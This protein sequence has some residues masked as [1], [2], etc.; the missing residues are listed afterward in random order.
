MAS[1]W[2]VLITWGQESKQVQ[3]PAHPGPFHH[4]IE[5]HHSSQP[6]L[7][8]TQVSS[9]QIS[10]SGLCFW[11]K[12]EVS[13]QW[14]SRSSPTY[15]PVFSSKNLSNFSLAPSSPNQL[16]VTKA[17]HTFSLLSPNLTWTQPNGLSFVYNIFFYSGDQ[18]LITWP[19]FKKELNINWF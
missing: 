5:A 6:S 9:L 3:Y 2:P 8:E 7:P 13:Q 16:T 11:G 1:S 10:S 12:P 14:P 15:T 17:I 19:K 4:F 18:L